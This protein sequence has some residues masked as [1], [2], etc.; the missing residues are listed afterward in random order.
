M[1]DI[2]ILGIP[3]SLREGSYNRALLETAADVAP[4]GVEIEI[5][6]LH[7]IPMYNSDVEKRGDPEPVAELKQRIADADGVLIATPEYQHGIPG[8]LK[9]ALDWASRPPGGSAMIDKPV[10]T[11]G[12]SP[13]PV[14]TARAHLQLRRTLI[15]LQADIV[16][17]PEVL[18]SSAPEKFEEGR[19]TDEDSLGFLTQLMETFTE[20]IRL[21]RDQQNA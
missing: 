5:L 15:Y 1:S 6:D 14:G 2:V 13:S 16:S 20:H 3:G 19:L 21:R 7:D 10:T 4:D 18:V 12:A 8:V 11:I 9:N 17:R